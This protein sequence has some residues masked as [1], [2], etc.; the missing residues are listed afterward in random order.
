[1]TM[2]KTI[3]AFAR[4]LPFVAGSMIALPSGAQEW[5]VR[6]ATDALAQPAGISRATPSPVAPPRGIAAIPGLS[7][8]GLQGTPLGWIE[9]QVLA[10]D[11]A[12][13]DLFGFRTLVVGDLAF[14]SA[15]A[16]LARQ[17][18]VYAYERKGGSWTEVQ[19]L[20][21]TPTDGT[22]PN[23]SDFFGWSISLSASGQYLAIGAPDVFSPMGG[24]T[25]GAYVFER[26]GSGDWVET[27]LL[28][29][30]IPVSVSM[31]GGNVVF[32]GETLVVG[33]G[34]YNRPVEGGR[35]A[36]HVYN[37]AGGSFTYSQLVQAGDSAPMD[38]IYFGNAL[39][40]DGGRVLVGAPG[41]DYST[42]A[43]PVGAAY[44]FTNVD[45]V[46][47]EAQK[48]EA[49]DGAA[50]DQFGFSIAIDG[51]TVLVGASAAN[52][53][54]NTHQGAAYV[55]AHDGSAFA[56]A[57]KLVRADGA[58][59]DQFGQ[60]VALSGGT[61]LVGMWSY[62]DEPGGT[63]PPPVPGRVGVF[64]SAGGAWTH[65]QDLAGSAGSDGD[66]FGWHVAVD[67]G[68]VL[69]GADADG[70]IAQYQGS[71]Y[72]YENDTLFANGFD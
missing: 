62:N 16:P 37:L 17:G 41:A 70:A 67:G 43:Y 13:G 44:V 2:S 54:E 8:P 58:A 32:S 33:E 19:R 72:F 55:F 61:A 4:S 36:A 22:P 28:L 59:F 23:W 11:A 65:R 60:S 18:A 35:G 31:F 21:G 26:D 5:S 51:D 20:M 12:G 40:A 48:L 57:Q 42:A 6:Y 53:G 69:V 71:A 39:A 27:Q 15:P 56:E 46:L 14:V 63:P 50:G 68:T 45:G 47:S 3:R 64:T 9:Q 10:S 49:S 30:P 52:I 1:M 66:S 38:D 24:P 34:S 29:P 7:A 25:G